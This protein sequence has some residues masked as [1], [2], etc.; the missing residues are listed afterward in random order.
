MSETLTRNQE[1]VLARLRG[2]P[3]AQSA[4]ELLDG[5]REEGLR[6]PTQIYRALEALILRGM[7]HRVE[8]LNAYVAC[9]QHDHD[10]GQEGHG[11]SGIVLAICSECGAVA[12]FD[13]GEAVGGLL[14][15]V[16]ATGF[17]T[18]AL[19]VELKGLCAACQP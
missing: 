11:P 10:H 12:E 15:Q 7:V 2:R 9:C 16:Q 8:S 4:Y 13:P 17:R 19:T 14:G 3:A 1:L 18:T 5:L 6:A